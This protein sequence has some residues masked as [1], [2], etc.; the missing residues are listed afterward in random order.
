MRHYYSAHML[1]IASNMTITAAFSTLAA[2]SGRAIAFAT[3]RRQISGAFSRT[4]TTMKA[5]AGQA[6]VVLVGCGAPNRGMGW[7]HGLQMVEKRCPSA[8]LDYV[9]EPWF[10][11]PGATSPGGP[12][13]LE[14]QAEWSA[15][16]VE[17]HPALLSEAIAQGCKCILLEKPGAPTV[18][19]LVA[20]RV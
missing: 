12:E 18:T 11:G 19:E 13:F 17:F 20:M 16:G 3:A 9:I 6:E 1:F 7:Y 4:T 14:T 10:M 2:Q 15:L 5:E 8:S